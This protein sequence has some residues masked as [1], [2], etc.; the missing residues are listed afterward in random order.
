M[1]I[2]SNK[3][4][5]FKPKDLYPDE[6]FLDSSNLPEFNIHQFEGRI[7]KP[8]GKNIIQI[9]FALFSLLVVI[10]FVQVTRLQ[11]VKGQNYFEISENNHLQLIPIFADRGVIYDRNKVSLAWNEPAEPTLG[12]SLRKYID[13]SGFGHLLGYINYPA[14]DKNNIYYRDEFVG[15]G[16][17][18]EYFNTELSGIHGL[19]MIERN[20]LMDVVSESLQRPPKDGA[21]LEL[22]I[23]SKMQAKLYEIISTTA[24]NIGFRGGSGILMNAK[25]GEILAI[26]SYPEYS[27][28]V[29]TDGEDGAEIRRILSD[30]KEP[31]LNRAISGLFTPGS[32]VKP[33]LALGALD[34]GIISPEKQILSTG[35]LRVPNPYYPG[36]YTSF[37]DWKAHGWVDMRHAIAVSSNVYFFTIGGGFQNQQGLG[38][39]NIEKYARMFGIGE[40][41]GID[42]FGEIDGIIPN[43]EWKEKNFEDGTWRIGDTYNTSIGQ[44][45][46]QVTPLQMIRALA[47]IANEGY[48]PTP[49]ILKTNK[50]STMKS[51]PI[52][53]SSFRVVK[54]GM[55]LGVTEGTAS[56]VSVPYVK[57]AAKTGTA[58]IG[59]TK[60]YVNSWVMG[61][62]PYENP[63][64]VFLVSME[65]GPRK[66]LVGGVSVMRQLLD[67][68]RWSAPEY[69][70]LGSEEEGGT[71]GRVPIE[72]TPAIITQPDETASFVEPDTPNIE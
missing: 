63:K 1:S 55:R 17:V 12:Y 29:M 65:H 6:V 58:E 41:T 39:K 48:L 47:G 23:D 34:E 69:F 45:G 44:Y 56:G 43:Q 64:Y 61:F 26:T 15:H 14:K 35:S 7:E 52:K 11:V 68:M 38:I 21:N 25:T 36:R 46:F 51:V 22:S 70:D 42:L 50:T 24:R 40:Q 20:A 2:F 32:I 9:T 62:F 53:V 10:F 18:E 66:N 13:L 16:G 49:T 31:F 3:R 28:Q 67:Y 30:A 72:E 33:F 71:M 60:S 57:I 27:P 4:N 5:K 59:T 19:Q 8:I 37:N 54:E